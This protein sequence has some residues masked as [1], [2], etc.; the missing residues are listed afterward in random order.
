MQ[1]RKWKDKAEDLESDQEFLKKKTLEA[2][3]KNKLL[4]T[5]IARLQQAGYNDSPTCSKCQAER[6]LK[7]V[8]HD[9]LEKN[10][11]FITES[12][13]TEISTA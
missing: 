5:A 12:V 10:P 8:I 1:V 3:R 2:K 11:F 7:E 6:P 9:E 4:K 13:S